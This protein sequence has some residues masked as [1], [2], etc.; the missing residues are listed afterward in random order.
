M[1]LNLDQVLLEVPCPGCGYRLQVQLV[2]AHTQVWRWCPC[3]R[4]RVRLVE[5]DGSVS[6]GLTGADEAMRELEATMKNL[7]R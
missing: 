7:F 2:D 6:V 4:T 1:L 3:C 5:P